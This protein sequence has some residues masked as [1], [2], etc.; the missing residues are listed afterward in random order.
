MKHL[1]KYF[2]AFFILIFSFASFVSA[3]VEFNGYIVKLKYDENVI[4][5]SPSVLGIGNTLPEI[6]DFTEIVSDSFDDADVLY[7]SRGLLTVDSLETVSELERSGFVSFYE[8]NAICYLDAYTPTNLSA[9][10]GID[11]I[12]GQY[13]WD[14]GIYGEGI[15]VGV[16]DSGVYPHDD[17]VSKLLPGKCYIEGIEDKTDTVDTLGHG[18]FV[19]SIIAAEANNISVVG[20]AHKA[21]IVPL[22]VTEGR[23]FDISLTIPAIFDAVDVFDCDVINMSLGSEMKSQLLFEAIAYACSKGVIVVAASGNIV[24]GHVA[25]MYPA[26]YDNVI[27]VANA[28][29]VQN[30][31]EISYSISSSSQYND[32]V[33]IAA[34][35]E[36][37]YG[38]GIENQTITMVG[39]GTSYAAPFVSA[40]AALVKSVLGDEVDSAVFANFLSYT[41][42]DSYMTTQ[43][44][45][46]Y[47]G[48]GLLDI[49]ALI[50][51]SLKWNNKKGFLSDVDFNKNT[52]ATSVYIHNPTQVD[53]T[54]NLLIANNNIVTIGETKY[55]KLS[56]LMMYPVL[57]SAGQSV[58]FSLTDR[59]ITG[60][61]KIFLFDEG[62]SFSPVST[63][64][65]CQI[66]N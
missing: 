22:R 64:R 50:D 59:E 44:G 57:V 41:A 4:E 65:E 36:L 31:D 26:A 47:W 6:E 38:N 51:Y 5:N 20:L 12:N 11:A 30:G 8:K 63:V 24:N 58:E 40:A 18:T 14:C 3:E 62:N 46:E 27:S 17:L 16:I 56:N 52:G 33:N 2:I 66:L 7:A 13:A 60:N 54:Y 37:V 48:S 1:N 19:S 21:S 28:K 45:S 15:R 53:K 55:S 42:D 34:P 29:K 23:T 25:T 39:S 61:L 49:K 35:G 43:M 32:S 9:Q 10:W